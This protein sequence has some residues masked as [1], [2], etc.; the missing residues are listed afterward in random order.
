MHVALDARTLFGSARRGIGKTLG[1][2]YHYL[3]EVRPDWHVTA[4]HRPTAAAD[5]A[6]TSDAPTPATHAGPSCPHEDPDRLKPHD[7]DTTRTTARPAMT[8]RPMDMP[9]DRFDAWQ[10]LRLPL[11]AR[12][13]GADVLHCPAN[14]CPTWMPL[15]TVVTIHDVIPLDLP[16][17]RPVAE[18]RRFERGVR[19]A[20]R[21]ARAIVTPS[22]Y[23]RRRL[24]DGWKADPRRVVV[25]PWSA[26][27]RLLAA[28]GVDGDVAATQRV[29]QWAGVDGPFVL[30][31]GAAE[32]RKNTRRVIESWAMVHRGIRK[33]WKL[34]VVGLDAATLASLHEVVQRLGLQR[35]VHLRGFADERDLPA[36]MRAAGVLLYPS[37]SEGFG[38]P[39][40]D[41][42]AT[43]TAVV[44]AKH[45]AIEEVAGAAAHFVDPTDTHSIAAGLQRVLS[46]PGYREHLLGSGRRQLQRF[47]WRESADRFA[48]VLELVADGTR[49]RAA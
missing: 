47:N 31:F 34:L 10:R 5:A 32:P 7:R 4:Y 2:L 20:C 23:T 9:G 30:H 21:R 6:E 1:E 36:L 25:A 45:T 44:T 8:P 41:A 19:D 13:S 11:A 46:E 12:L 27:S 49:R 29:L 39:V 22:R 42:F 16:E 43:D 28:R 48:R 3:R 14:G 15:P 17:G 40:L 18:L 35:H 33:R 37:L 38:L 24:I 26:D